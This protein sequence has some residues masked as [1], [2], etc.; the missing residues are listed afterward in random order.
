MSALFPSVTGTS[1]EFSAIWT[2]IFLWCM[3]ELFCLHSLAGLV[4]F[5]SFREYKYAGF[6]PLIYAAYGMLT[7]CFFGGI[8]SLLITG[9]YTTMGIDMP[10]YFGIIYGFGLATSYSIV[11]ILSFP[12]LI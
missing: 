5:I 1:G 12:S 10:D 8:S 11:S 4:A 6:F 2:S 3:I 9:V 7:C